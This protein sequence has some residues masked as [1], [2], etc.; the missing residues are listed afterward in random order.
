LKI[1]QISAAYKPAYIYGG[2]TMSVAKLCESLGSWVCRE[3]ESPKVRKSDSWNEKIDI[4][5][6]TTTA[7]GKNELEVEPNR[8]T[9]VDGVEVTYF[10]R[11]TKDHTHFSPALLWALR[12]EIL[13]C[14]H[15]GKS[16]ELIIHIHAWWN[17]V[18]VLSCAVAFWYKIPVVLSPRGMLTSYTQTNRNSFSKNLIH[19]LIGKRL[20]NYCHIHAT[21]EQEKQDILSI[22]N[23]KSIE[24]ISNLVEFNNHLV[25]NSEQPT[26]NKEIPV[27]PF[28]IIFLSRIEEKKGLE[29]LF[30]SL[31]LLDFDFILTIAGLGNKAYIE[32]LKIKA[33]HLKLA[34][35]LSWLGQVKN[36]DKFDLLSKKDVM[37]LTSY[38]ENFANVVIE[39]LSVGTAVIVS[40]QVG[41]ANYVTENNLGWITELNVHSVA[42]K[43]NQ[44][45]QDYLKRNKIRKLAPSLIFKDFNDKILVKKYINLYKC[46]LNG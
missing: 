6:F 12:N 32:N 19:K 2:P 31:A 40:N 14:N 18:S 11:L 29:L 20:L 36:E 44:S 3:S 7:N 23:P 9:I 39:S 37:V 43:L 8:S 38:N 26:T 5:V 42:N 16:N 4:Q 33:K 21:S 22:I 34:D 35:K 10:K 1:I 24:V 30:D 28:K 27:I 41:L 45:Y 15:N 25:T 17:L 46:I 13:R